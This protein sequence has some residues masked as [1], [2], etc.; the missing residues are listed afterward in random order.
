MNIL[1]QK[2]ISKQ[3]TTNLSPDLLEKDDE[4]IPGTHGPFTWEKTHINILYYMLVSAFCSLSH[5]W[6]YTIQLLAQ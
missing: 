4:I 2:Q 5:T 6:D 3:Y 1:Q